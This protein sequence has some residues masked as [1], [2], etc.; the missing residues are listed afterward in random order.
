MVR[1]RAALLAFAFTTPVIMSCGAAAQGLPR[2]GAGGNP[3]PAGRALAAN[4]LAQ[5]FTPGAAIADIRVEGNQRIEEG[6]IKSY[7]LVAPG[8]QFDSE[9]L[10]RSLKTLFATGLFSDVVLRR[11][12][13]VLVVRVSENPIVNKIV[14]EGNKKIN[15]DNLRSELTLRPRAV[16]TPALAAL[17][18]Q[19]IL[20]QYA[21]RGRFGARAEPK[22][23]QLDQNRVDVVF[24]IDD[25][26]STLIAR[27]PSSPRRR[28]SLP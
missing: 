12:G 20:D 15:D 7:M 9:R 18:R 17:D 5:V 10:D 2:P 25:G 28:A 6:T 11:D 3:R 1:T 14:F 4:T 16:F 13:N 19:K 23:I 26:T 21:K 24:E 27:N 8:D 22:I